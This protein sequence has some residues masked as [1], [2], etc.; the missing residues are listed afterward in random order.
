MTRTASGRSRGR[1]WARLSAILACLVVAA[2]MIYAQDTEPKTPCCGP[3][4]TPAA[5]PGNMPAP[6]NPMQTASP[7]EVAM[8]AGN[9]PVAA[10][11]FQVALSAG[12]APEDGLQVKTIWAA[13]AIEVLFPEVT[14]I[15]GYREDPLRWHPDGLAIDVMI[16]DHDSP[17]GIALGDQIAGFALANTKRWGIDHVIWR[18]KI[19][20]GIRSGSWTADLG[21]ETANH[22]DHVHI[23]T[24]GGGYPTGDETYFIGSM[25]PPPD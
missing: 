23:A 21:N 22:Y 18:Q 16:P 7:H 19:Y 2:A 3:D 12:I 1:G 10:Q 15:Y 14:T 4:P 20:L 17:E 25:T 13:R 5:A 9:A 11:D 8:L 24:T 6:R